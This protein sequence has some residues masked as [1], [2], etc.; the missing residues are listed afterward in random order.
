MH[1]AKRS[2]L[3]AENCALGTVHIYRASVHKIG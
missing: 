2:A 1:F 3:P